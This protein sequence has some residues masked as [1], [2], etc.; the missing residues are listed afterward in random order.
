MK[1]IARGVCSRGKSTRLLVSLAALLLLLPLV[2]CGAGRAGLRDAT[3]CLPSF[4]YRGGW[5]GGD[6]AY[7]ILLDDGRT[8]WLFGDTFVSDEEAR[9]DRV[10]MDV[11][12][13]TTLAI[14]TCGGDGRFDIRYVL[15]REGE[16]FVS[17]FG[18][19][20]WLWP[21]DPFKVLDSLYIPLAV[22][23]PAPNREGPFKFTV[24]GHR[25]ALVRNYRGKDPRDWSVEYLDWSAAVP[26]GVA[27]L[28]TTSVVHGNRVYFYPLCVPSEKAPAVLGNILVRIPTDRLH[29][30][31]GG[32]EYYAHDG[33]WQRGVDPAKAKIVLDAGVSELSVRYHERLK[34]WIA[35]YLSVHNGG[36][37]LLYR[38]AERLEGPWSAP[39]ALIA[40]IPERDPADPK[41]HENTFCYAGKE[42]IQF[43]TEG[44]L[45]T[46]YVCNSLGDADRPSSSIRSSLFLYRPVVNEVPFH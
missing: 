9:R 21:Q 13:G 36:D 28:A 15:K 43:A 17:S 4:P 39:R 38:S 12:L 23:D 24:S 6:G 19:N 27:A 41:Y 5:Y 18:G 20:R 16:R 11:V 40:A 8:L 35:V 46:T 31:A 2:S 34:R 1:T 29:D 14:S 26:P 22:I 45:V 44:K 42:H 25:I 30:P 3:G 33:S 10:G 37:R 32:M 7:S